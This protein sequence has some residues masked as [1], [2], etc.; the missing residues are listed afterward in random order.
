MQRWM[1]GVSMT[2]PFPRFLSG[3]FYYDSSVQ[4]ITGGRTMT[5]YGK[6]YITAGSLNDEHIEFDT[7]F[8]DGRSHKFVKYAGSKVSESKFEGDSFLGEELRLEGSC[9]ITTIKNDEVT[10]HDEY[11]S[12]IRDIRMMCARSWVS[13]ERLAR[14]E[15]TRRKLT[16]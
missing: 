3:Y 11:I 9:S 2:E 5:R 7:V 6:I 10:N 14:V 13:P 12:D 8:Y 4:R 1:V 15:D 16:G